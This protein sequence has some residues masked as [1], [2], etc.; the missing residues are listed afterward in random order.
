MKDKKIL[1]KLE[2]YK[3]TDGVGNTILGNPLIHP[4]TIIRMM[5]HYK[6]QIAIGTCYGD[7][8]AYIEK[9]DW[10]FPLNEDVT[11]WDCGYLDNKSKADCVYG[12][13]NTINKAV[14][15]CIITA[16]EVG[17]I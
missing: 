6:V 13:G 12:W 11:A 14:C 1:K 7:C 10:S 17:V 8:R 16:K 2:K 15:K 3:I 5:E 4:T 9:K